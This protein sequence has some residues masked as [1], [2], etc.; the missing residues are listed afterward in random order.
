M[1]VTITQQPTDWSPSD[2]PLLYEFSSN[3]TTQPNFS[4]IVRTYVAGVLT[5]EDKVFVERGTKAH[6]DASTVVK[7][8]IQRPNINSGLYT[9]ANYSNEVYV[10]IYENYGT[11][12]TDHAS[13]TSTTINVFKACFSNKVWKSW[14]ATD[15][16][17]LKYLTNVPRNETMYQ[18]YGDYILNII[19]DGIPNEL[20]INAYDSNGSLIDSYS[21]TQSFLISQV[22]LS[23]QNLAG[24]MTLTGLS[25]YT[26]QVEGSEM[27]TIHLH[28]Y[29][30]QTDMCNSPYVLQWLNEFGSYDQ[31]IFDHNI[32]FSG[33]VKERT[34]GKQFGNWVSGSFTYSLKD[35]G[36]IRVGTRQ[37]DKGVVYTKYITQTLQHWL[38]ELYKSPRHYL[39]E[40][41][42][43]TTDTIRI[44]STQFTFAQDRF[45]D[46]I[47]ESVAFEY[48]N[49]HNSISI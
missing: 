11:T 4:F 7:N 16:V 36:S 22:N 46:L 12:P 32:E 27:F 49:E 28:P 19:T 23:P 40:P 24:I 47:S 20:L 37:T 8:A 34:Y 41:L 18:S 2:N 10:K 3:Q 13:A 14:D 25:Y 38:C 26:V 42:E 39:T 9:E 33:S 5:A 31:F 15:W 35:S 21:E 48:T 17:G 43:G 45:E 44:T 6:Y 1:A 30:L 29:V